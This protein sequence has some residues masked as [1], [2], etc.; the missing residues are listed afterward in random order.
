MGENV[1]MIGIDTA[2]RVL[3][4]TKVNR[5]GIHLCANPF[6]GESVLGESSLSLWIISH[7]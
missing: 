7:R 6:K 5:V 4:G 1:F 3:F 2:H